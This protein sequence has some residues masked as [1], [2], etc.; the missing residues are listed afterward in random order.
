MTVERWSS[1][2]LATTPATN[3][4][5]TGNNT[6][7]SATITTTAN[8]SILTW[9]STDDSSTDPAT[10]AYLSSATEDGLADGHTSVSSVQYYAYQTA[11]T[12]GSQTIG[13]SAPASQKWVM[14]GIE[15]LDSP[16]N[17]AT[18]WLFTA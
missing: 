6:Q 12:A 11:A 8:N 2:L 1:A 4:T 3:S 14:V 16:A 5:I 7:P 18:T 10:R 17:T 13:M 9:V 15:V